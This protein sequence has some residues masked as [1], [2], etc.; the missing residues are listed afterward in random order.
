MIG[1]TMVFKVNQDKLSALKKLLLQDSS[2]TLLSSTNPYESFRIRYSEGLVVGYT[3]GK[4]VANTPV[5]AELVSQAIQ[6]LGKDEMGYEVIIGSDEAGKGEWLGPI[7]IAAVA[8]TPE[9]S[10]L[11]I[12]KGVMD[13]K[14]LSTPRILELVGPIKENSLMSCMFLGIGV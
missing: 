2:A 10:N 11:L 12:A 6:R 14:M 8:L 3:S 5:A 13:S 1:L 7:T 9:Q 4:I